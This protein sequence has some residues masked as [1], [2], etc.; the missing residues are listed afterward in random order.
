MIEI[1]S[2]VF[3]F[4]WSAPVAFGL[5]AAYWAQ[6]TGRNPWL[7]LLFGMLLMPLA[8]I[9]LLMLNGDRKPASPGNDLGHLIAVNKDLP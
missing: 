4:G 1:F 6:Q 5:F 2:A 9:A 3:A 8:G 7:W